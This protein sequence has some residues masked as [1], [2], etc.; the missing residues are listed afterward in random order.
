M[1]ERTRSPYSLSFTREVHPTA[2][3]DV[4]A[5]FVGEFATNYL[6]PSWRMIPMLGVNS[7]NGSVQW[8]EVPA[9]LRTNKPPWTDNILA[10]STAWGT[11]GTAKKINWGSQPGGT[12]GSVA[13]TWSGTVRAIPASGRR[14]P[15]NMRST[16]R[17]VRDNLLRENCMERMQSLPIYSSILRD[18]LVNSQDCNWEDLWDEPVDQ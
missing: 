11:G 18:R 10:P 7:I 17:R 9:P 3:I 13:I 14:S 4:G 12:Y 5:G 2:R 16:A 1:C 8:L 6:T 15:E